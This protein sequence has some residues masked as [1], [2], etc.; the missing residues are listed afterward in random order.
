SAEASLP[1]SAFHS[2]ASCATAHSAEIDEPLARRRISVSCGCRERRLQLRSE[3]ILSSGT[4]L[5]GFS[6]NVRRHVGVA[7]SWE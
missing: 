6:G 3:A 4:G 1:A 7:G 2:C 5:L